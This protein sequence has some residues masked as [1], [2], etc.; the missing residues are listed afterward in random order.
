MC[1][2]GV[3]LLLLLVVVFIFNFF[4]WRGGGEVGVCLLGGIVFVCF[5]VVWF[6]R[7]LVLV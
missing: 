4:N 7:G 6:F 5:F 2:I 1:F 3:G